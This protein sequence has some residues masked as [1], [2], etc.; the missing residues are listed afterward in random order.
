MDN[1]GGFGVSA[2][3]S[4][5]IRNVLE[6]TQ[7]TIPGRSYVLK[8]GLVLKVSLHIEFYGQPTKGCF[9]IQAIPKTHS[10]LFKG[11]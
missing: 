5:W 9:Q 1:F 8:A 2:F 4:N 10:H 3:G 7:L 11:S 6:G